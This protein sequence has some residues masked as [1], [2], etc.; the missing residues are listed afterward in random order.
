MNEQIEVQEK[1]QIQTLTES[2]ELDKVTIPKYVEKALA[3]SKRWCE[4]F[5]IPTH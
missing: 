4:R 2:L 5:G 1:N 3:L